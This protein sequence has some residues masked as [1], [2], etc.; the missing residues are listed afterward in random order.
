[1][2][3]VVA[4][5]KFKGSLT[6][7]EVAAA[8]AAGLRAGGP[9]PEVVTMPVA[10]GGDGTLDAAVAAGFERVPVTAAGPT[11]EPVRRRLR[12]ARRARGGRAGRRLRPGP[13]ARRAARA[14]DRV[15]LR[16]GRGASARRWTP[17]A[18]RIVLGVGGSASTDGGAGL[19]QALGARL[20]D[21][22]GEPVRPGGG[23]A[24]ATWPRLD[25]TG[26]HPAWPAPR[27][28][29]PATSTTR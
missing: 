13:A 10:D 22:G 5:D 12:P 11:G 24:C 25:L 2:K 15:Q 23:G 8:I 28:W 19:L 1:M 17:G 4:P 14:A 21:A 3:I 27:S 7:A 26:L 6:A 16:H 20:L 18:R 9:A 29:W